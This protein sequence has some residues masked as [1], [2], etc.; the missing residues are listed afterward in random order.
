MQHKIERMLN[1]VEDDIDN[2]ENIRD[3]L[4]ISKEI[5][6]K[7]R[8]S[9]V[10]NGKRDQNCKSCCQIKSK[11]LTRLQRCIIHTKEDPI[12]E[13][14]I[15]T[16]LNILPDHIHLKNKAGCDSL[17]LT[18]RYL[19]TLTTFKTLDILLT[20]DPNLSSRNRNGQ[21]A[22]MIAAR[23]FTRYK[24][25]DI[26]V[27]LLINCGSKLNQ[28]DRDGMT[29]LMTS[30]KFYGN[31]STRD[32]VHLLLKDTN[33]NVRNKIGQTAISF[34]CLNRKF[35]FH[36]KLILTLLKRSDNHD[37]MVGDKKLIKFLYD[38]NF[39]DNYI[40]YSLKKGARNI[41]LLDERIKR[42]IES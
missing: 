11:S 17:M 16:Y 34:A 6:E 26:V 27:D 7:K 14:Y 20:F 28:R 33:V 40:R 8:I 29:A 36:K 42:L 4:L 37:V 38:E 13:E 30:I 10:L 1:N 41:D 12:F 15:E 9:H 3:F 32:I 2:L 31:G 23:N 22:L 5:F 24:Y 18:V 25:M 39:S 21:T 19:G 35:L